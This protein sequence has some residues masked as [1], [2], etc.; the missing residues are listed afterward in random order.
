MSE[1]E[2][3]I[4]FV[5]NWRNINEISAEGSLNEAQAVKFTTDLQ[6]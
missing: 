2:T 4:E 3:M 1:V 6:A 5:N